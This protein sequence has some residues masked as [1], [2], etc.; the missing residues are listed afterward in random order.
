L[1][2]AHH[3]IVTSLL[4]GYHLAFA[5]GASCAAAAIVAAAALVRTPRRREPELFIEQESRP[6]DAFV[7]EL[8]H[9]AA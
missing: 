5:I 6:S 4:A 2:I 9:Q 1:K 8:E 7:A 3:P